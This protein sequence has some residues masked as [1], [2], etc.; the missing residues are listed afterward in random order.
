MIIS[1]WGRFHKQHCHVVRPRSLDDVAEVINT[2]SLI[3]RGNGRSYGDSAQN[4]KTTVQML[5]LNRML[6]FDHDTGVLVTEAGVLLA[7]V[8]EHFLPRG[9]FPAVTPGTRYVTVGG[10][11]AADV[12]G[13][14]H[15]I[16]G[17]F[18]N[19]VEWLEIMTV[20]G[21]TQRVSLH[22]NRKLFCDTLGGMGL[23][24]IIIRVAFRL[25]RVETGWIRQKAICAPDLATVLADFE[26]HADAPYSVAWIDCLA[27]GKATGR[28]VLFLGEHAKRDSL[29]QS[30]KADVFA[31][32]GKVRRR[33]SFDWPNAALNRLS[34]RAFNQVY[35]RMH[36]GRGR[37]SLV[38]WDKYFYPLDRLEDW[39]RMYGRRGFF[40]YQCVVPLNG[41]EASLRALLEQI[42]QSGLGSFLAVLKRMGPQGNGT[43]SFPMEGYTLALD[44]PATPDAL[45]L[46]GRL[47]AVVE[48]A[49]GRLYLAKDGRLPAATLRAMDPRVSIFAAARRQ[50]GAG[51]FQSSQSERLHL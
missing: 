3:A 25:K 6:A 28:S 48:T 34:V 1:G 47:D 16:E 21:L 17:G 43:L 30:I 19:F 22:Q 23:T 7:D 12:H 50:D 9:W 20:D 51:H 37:P 42:G 41:A 45:A 15:H 38:S 44:F 14:N 36:S 18:G 49:G 2:D 29:P 10:M 31:A 24:G 40:Q 32:P 46:M 27:K 39:N 8:I 13:K 35:Y 26:R 33:L 5:G 4:P 11:V